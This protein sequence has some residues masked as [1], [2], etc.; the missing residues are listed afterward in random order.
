[1]ATKFIG[2]IK[3]KTLHILAYT[4]GRCHINQI[5][6]EQKIEFETLEE[7]MK[8]PNEESPI[9]HECGVCFRKMREVTKSKN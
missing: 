8:Y 3:N 6:E 2:N 9:F 1:M 4:D 5:R 7:A